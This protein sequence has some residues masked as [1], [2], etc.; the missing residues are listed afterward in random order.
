[1]CKCKDLE[2]MNLMKLKKVPSQNK[3]A[4][5]QPFISRRSAGLCF[6]FSKKDIGY[7]GSRSFFRA[8]RDQCLELGGR[9][10]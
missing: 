5:P 2:Y 1:M 7:G 3:G 10:S 6:E 4:Q 9:L 8:C